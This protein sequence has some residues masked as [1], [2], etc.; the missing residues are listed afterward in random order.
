MKALFVVDPLASLDASLDT[1]IGLMHA[2]QERGGEV[3]VAEGHEL[4][5]RDGQAWAHARRIKLAP[6]Y[7]DGGCRWTVPDPWYDAAP[8]EPVH[9]DEMTV[10]FMRLEPPV[11][12]DY[13]AA[14][15]A[16]DLV[17]PRRTAQVNAPAG[18]RRWSEHLMPLAFPDLAPPTLVTARAEAIRSFLT[19]HGSVVIKPVDGFSGRGVFLLTGG[20]P[21]VASLVETATSR[22]VRSVIVQPY[23]EVVADGNKRLYVVDCVAVGATIRYP[24]PGDFRIVSPDAAAELTSRDRAIVDRLAP[25]LQ[26]HGLR[27]VGLD[28]I[29]DHLIEVNVTSPGA[30]RKANALLGTSYCADLVDHV[31]LHPHWSPS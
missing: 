8:P 3:W 28:V 24:V 12:L 30:I 2:A 11:D 10:V 15:Y 14:T 4:E 29:G 9:L 23:L 19:E 1:G 31:V 6:S 20:D 17:D 13:L 27:C 18:L 22:G 25:A 16:L 5:V 21:N 7:P 26:Q